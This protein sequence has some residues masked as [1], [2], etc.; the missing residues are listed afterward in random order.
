M[1]TTKNTLL[2]SATVIVLLFSTLILKAQEEL[3]ICYGDMIGCGGDRHWVEYNCKT[4]LCGGNHR[5]TESSCMRC[6]LKVK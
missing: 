4:D 2:L 1:K 3:P 6:E 5:A